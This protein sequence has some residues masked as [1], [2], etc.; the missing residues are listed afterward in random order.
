[1]KK[2]LYLTICICSIL[3]ITPRI[4]RAATLELRFDEATFNA[5]GQAIVQLLLAPSEQKINALG[6]ELVIVSGK[7]S[8]K[9]IQSGNSI[10]SAWLQTP[11]LKNNTVSFSGIIPG[12][13]SG[14]YSPFNKDLQPGIVMSVA[15]T[16]EE[17]GKVVLG[18]RNME[19]YADNGDI[20]PLNLEPNQLEIDFI[21][22]NRSANSGLSVDTVP[23]VNFSAQIIKI[24]EGP[25]DWF[26]A[27]AAEDTESG[28]DHYEIQET[29]ELAPNPLAWKRGE[30]PFR[31]EDQSRRSTVF[32]KAIDHSG[33]EAIMSVPPAPINYSL[34]YWIA[35]G[36]LLAFLLIYGFYYR[37]QRV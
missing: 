7:A 14:L 9:E 4:S 5:N 3:L 36:I 27:F 24:P 10:I 25:Q 26:V 23:P 11:Q 18:L 32:I 37:W 34:W 2:Y 21:K 6:G 17:R 12:G 1:M 31:L 15:L 29:R 28:I 33:Q 30:S 16:I 20:Q 13:F 22:S 8:F 19:V 35:G